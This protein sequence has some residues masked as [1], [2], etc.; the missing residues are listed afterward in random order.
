MDRSYVFIRCTLLYY[1]R[2]IDFDF[3]WWRGWDLLRFALELPLSFQVYNNYGDVVTAP[4]LDGKHHKVFCRRLRGRVDSFAS[5]NQRRNT[6]LFVPE[7]DSPSSHLTSFLV[8]NHIPQPITGQYQT[9]IFSCSRNEHYFRFWDY[10][11]F[12]ISI[13]CV[14]K[15][16]YKCRSRL[17]STSITELC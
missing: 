8:W 4:F 1:V 13:T 11:W 9:F 6:V 5:F 7:Q 3:R 16:W 17:N 15:R 14:R 12:Q 2:Y 10:P